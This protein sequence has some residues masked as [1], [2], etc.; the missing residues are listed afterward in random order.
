MP[1]GLAKQIRA[2]LEERYASVGGAVEVY[3]DYESPDRFRVVTAQHFDPGRAS[4]EGKTDPMH[5]DSFVARVRAD[6]STFGVNVLT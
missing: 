3:L 2:Y 1:P 6:L 4:A 5:S